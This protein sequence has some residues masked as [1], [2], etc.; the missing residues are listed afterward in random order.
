[1]VLTTTPVAAH[2]QVRP[3]GEEGSSPQTNLASI[4]ALIQRYTP[5]HQVPAEIVVH[6]GDTLGSVSKEFCGTPDDWTGIYKKNKKI[7]GDNPDLILPGQKLLKDCRDVPVARPRIVVAAA[8]S[9]GRHAIRRAS[10]SYHQ[11]GGNLSF[12]GLERLWIAAGGDSSAARSAAAVAEC[13]SGGRQYAYNP[14][15]ASGYWQILG[16]VVGGN[17]YDPMTNARNAVSKWRASGKTFAQWVC[18]P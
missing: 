11:G 14:S 9:T 16:Q 4:T 2:A 18:Q 17:I 1:M 8:V 13:E 3:S 7:I 5:K 10:S 6:R 12:S 15:G